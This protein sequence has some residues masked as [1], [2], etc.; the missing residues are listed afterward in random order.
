MGVILET[1][2]DALSY[3]NAFDGNDHQS[4]GGS[5]WLFAV[6]AV[7][8]VSFL[9][10]AA[11]S[12][13]PRNGE[14]IFHYLFTI[15]LLVG[16]I[17]Y[18]SMASGLAYRLVEQAN[19]DQFAVRQIY[20][21]KYVFWAVAFPVVITALDLL[22]GVSWA[23]IIYHVTLAWVWIASYLFSAFTATHYKWGFF[24]FGSLAW[25]LLAV[26]TLTSGRRGAS[27]LG[28]STHYLGL[29]A[30]VNF[31]WFLYVLAFSLTDAGYQ[32][33]VPGTHIWFGILDLLL[34][35]VLA[36]A[37]VFLSGRWDYGRLNMHFTQFGR[38]PQQPGTFPEKGVAHGAGTG[39]T[40]A[41][42]AG[43]GPGVGPGVGHAG[44]GHNGAGHTGVGGN[45]A[46]A[47][48]HGTNAAPVQQT[49]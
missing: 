12:F 46:Y 15:A 9:A 42:V 20:W 4:E 1:R 11:L 14:R 37:F 7:F 34:V 13:K 30:F 16:T 48:T 32:I 40:A 23:T 25:V 49:V 17:A 35:P 26:S 36:F 28:V 21:A 19:S 3:N 39:T 2:N 22:S 29:A 6:T 8:F 24:V 44:V 27:R 38:V 5:S 45:A 31:L 47:P 33:R 43:T 18:F 41:P 10:I